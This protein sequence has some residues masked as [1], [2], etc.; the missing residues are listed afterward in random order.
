MVSS[1]EPCGVAWV[2]K[3]QGGRLVLF[4]GA[5]WAIV[6]VA[7]VGPPYGLVLE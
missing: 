7:G 1:V 5:D 6:A 2:L 4:S 3:D